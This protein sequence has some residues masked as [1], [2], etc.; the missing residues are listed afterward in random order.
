MKK[1]VGFAII[2][3]GLA[4]AGLLVLRIWGISL[5]SH[6]TLLRSGATLVVLAVGWAVLIICWFAFFR[7]PAAGYDSSGGQRVQPRLPRRDQK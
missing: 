2:L 3:V 1:L 7:N 4:L 6:D 5:V